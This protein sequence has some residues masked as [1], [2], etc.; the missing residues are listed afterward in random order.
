[1]LRGATGSRGWG[2]HCLKGA[3]FSEDRKGIVTRKDAG[4]NQNMTEAKKTEN[5]MV[6]GERL[7]YLQAAEAQNCSYC[8]TAHQAHVRCPKGHFVCDA[9]HGKEARKMI[10]D[11][12]LASRSEDPVEIAELMMSHP[13]LPMLSCDHAFIAAGALLAALRNSPYGSRI[14][15]AEVREVFGR[16][17]KQAHGGFCGL[18][19]VCGVAPAIGAV[20]SLFLD[21]RCGADREQKTTMEAVVRV[22]KVISDLT[23]PSCCKAYVRGAVAEAAGFLAEKFGVVLPVRTRSVVCSHASRH[24]HGCREERCPYFRRPS[25]DIFAEA[26]F[27][28]GTTSCVT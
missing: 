24:P 14:G 21:S 27:I 18:T 11:T 23:G 22:S 9:C 10:E 3:V 12:V 2:L 8:G 6:C 28:P 26:G 16:T 15:E 7:N 5:C 19:G 25:R 13:G 20:V 1:M 17:E 4:Y